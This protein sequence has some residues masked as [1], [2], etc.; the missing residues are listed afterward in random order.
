MLP[1]KNEPFG[2]VGITAYYYATVFRKNDS[3]PVYTYGLDF[4]YSAGRTHTKGA[5]A[6]NARFMASS[7]IKN[8]GNFGA[9]FGETA[10]KHGLMY[11]TPILER[12]RQLFEVV[13]NN[14]FS[15]TESQNNKIS[16]ADIL[17]KERE[18][19]EELKALLTG[20]KQMDADERQKEIT[21]LITEREYLY[22]HF[23]DGHRFVY[24]QSFLNRIRIEVD[25]YL[26]VLS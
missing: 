12:Y 16:L 13:V 25:Y 18:A 26:K 15:I 3:V 5:M 10:I 22:L 7:R 17:K 20:D 24:T 21:R 4:A 14:K 8:D 19:L 11:T 6:D 23:P 1:P 2:S 9:A